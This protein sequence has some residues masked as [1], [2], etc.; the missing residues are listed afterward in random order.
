MFFLEYVYRPQTAELF[1][2][3]VLMAMVFYGMP[4]LAENNKPR[5]LYH[6]KNRGYRKWSINRPDKHRNDLSKAERELGGIPSSPAVISIHA[7]A[8]ES[9]IEN[10]VGFSDQGTGN[11]YFNRTLLD[12]ANYDIGNRTKFD[13]TVS[14]GLAIM[15][16]QKYVIKAQRKD[17]EINVNFARYNNTG[18]VSSIIK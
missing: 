15:A 10:N 7:E 12:W 17:T 16:N 9:Y 4:V 5:L 11:M 3:D 18:T 2:E 6:L 14:S 1:Y 13:A 8:I